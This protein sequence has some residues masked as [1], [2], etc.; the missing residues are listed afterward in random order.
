MATLTVSPRD[1]SVGK[2]RKKSEDKQVTFRLSG[3]L[4]ARLEAAAGGMELDI[5]SLLRLLI[6]ENLPTYERRAKDIEE[7]ERGAA[8]RDD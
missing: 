6:R 4:H 5:S 8:P 3:E 2:D 7:R 1:A